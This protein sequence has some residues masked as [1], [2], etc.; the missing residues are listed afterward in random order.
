M[1]PSAQA[2]AITDDAETES[3]ADSA[4]AL[5]SGPLIEP[6]SEDK[7]P[8]LALSTVA[9]KEEAAKAGE[10]TKVQ[11]AGGR[12]PVKQQDESFV[13]EVLTAEDAPAGEPLYQFRVFADDRKNGL[14]KF[15]RTV[16]PL[17]LLPVCSSRPLIPFSR[18]VCC[19][20]RGSRCGASEESCLH[21][22]FLLAS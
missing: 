15:W 13:V 1:A 7:A 18:S 12:L 9:P 6:P 16:P 8:K 10:A 19:C 4:I 22:L 2:K 3:L 20:S 11:P 14:E 21:F 5:Q 17:A